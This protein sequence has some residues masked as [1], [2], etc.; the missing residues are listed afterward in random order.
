[1]VD[2]FCFFPACLVAYVSFL[3]LEGFATVN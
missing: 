3:P 1:V 2:S